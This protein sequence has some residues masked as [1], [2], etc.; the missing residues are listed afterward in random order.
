MRKWLTKSLWWASMSIH[1]FCSLCLSHLM[2]MFE[3]TMRIKASVRIQFN[4]I[5]CNRAI[6]ALF[7]IMLCAFVHIKKKISHLI[8]DCNFF[9]FHLFVH[10]SVNA[11]KYPFISRR[12]N[13]Q[14]SIFV[15]QS[16]TG[17]LFILIIW[18]YCFSVKIQ[19]LTLSDSSVTFVIDAIKKLFCIQCIQCAS[20][21]MKIFWILIWNWK[22]FF[23]HGIL[24]WIQNKTKQ[25]KRYF[26]LITLCWNML[27]HLYESN[28]T[29]IT[30]EFYI[31]YQSKHKKLPKCLNR[32]Y[33]NGMIW[34][35]CK[36]QI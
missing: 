1:V 36:C 12:I 7:N 35:P 32:F 22:T 28:D 18:D 11:V 14:K 10:E 13:C 33:G 3:S 9:F 8:R 27:D 15:I 2:L 17:F 4:G 29:A 34:M 5:I 30:R 31:N 24:I 20:K 26:F 19:I 25:N 21:V 23:F 6:S 16:T